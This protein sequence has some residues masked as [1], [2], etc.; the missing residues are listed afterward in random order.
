MDRLQDRSVDSE[1][2]DG[3]DELNELDTSDIYPTVQAYEQL[4]YAHSSLARFPKAGEPTVNMYEYIDTL[5]A[6]WDLGVVP[7]KFTV[8]SLYRALSKTYA[9]QRLHRYLVIVCSTLSFIESDREKS[10]EHSLDAMR[11]L[12][13]YIAL[14]EKS[15]ETDSQSVQEELNQYRRD[16]GE[17]SSSED[18]D[19][20]EPT[21]VPS[22]SDTTQL[23]SPAERD[24]DFC[25]VA[26]VGT[27]LLLTE[28]RLDGKQEQEDDRLELIEEALKT[29]EKATKILSNKDSRDRGKDKISGHDSSEKPQPKR[30]HSKALSK[31]RSAVNSEVHMWFGIARAEW[32][33]AEADPEQSRETAKNALADLQAAIDFLPNLPSPASPTTPLTPLTPVLEAPVVPRQTSDTMRALRARALYSL[34]YAQLEARDV[35]SAVATAKQAIDTVSNPATPVDSHA[36]T[37]CDNLKIWHLFVLALT[38]RKDLRRATEVAN[39]ALY[40]DSEQDDSDTVNE[41]YENGVL[42]QPSLKSP[43]SRGLMN[44]DAPWPASPSHQFTRADAPYDPSATGP[45]NTASAQHGKTSARE[46]SPHANGEDS[47]SSFVNVRLPDGSSSSPAAGTSISMSRTRSP[48]IAASHQGSTA[49]KFM[50]KRQE[51]MTLRTTSPWDDLEAEIDLMITR[52]KCIEAVEGPEIA[53]QDLQ[54]NVFTRFSKK[55]DDLERIC[56]FFRFR[57]RPVGVLILHPTAQWTHVRQAKLPLKS[58]GLGRRPR[59]LTHIHHLRHKTVCAWH[60][61]S[62][63]SVHNSQNIRKAEQGQFSVA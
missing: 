33:L 58:L 8:E 31:E 35:K 29:I 34:A 17:V 28:S 40:G 6:F 15:R 21:G 48:S 44:E 11:N 5:F 2:S 23:Y 50:E 55:R 24:E 13:L 12:R 39:L 14:F 62:R 1:R 19:I 7:G 47:M 32:A 57:G 53:L 63:S 52:N 38:A 51:P 18:E 46:D 10:K 27:R 22:D 45:V 59:Q 60:S 56:E 4:L 3:D 9:S 25:R 41:G 42:D 30:Q 61:N 20:D 49:A 43:A 36:F 16:H 54:T 37:L 26:C